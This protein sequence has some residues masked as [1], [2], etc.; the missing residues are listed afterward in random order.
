MV[1]AP[2]LGLIPCRARSAKGCRQRLTVLSSV[3]VQ[4]WINTRIMH[5]KCVINSSYN[6]FSSRVVYREIRNANCV[7]FF[8]AS[9][10]SKKT[11]RTRLSHFTVSHSAP[12]CK[13]YISNRYSI[14]TLFLHT[15]HSH[16]CARACLV[17]AARPR[18]KCAAGKGRVWHR[19]V[20]RLCR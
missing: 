2:K 13:L 8:V 5:C 9:S 6:E 14:Q 15:I 3:H 4:R 1:D 7:R 19:T 16:P 20:S 12:L 18:T 10:S 17:P 11:S